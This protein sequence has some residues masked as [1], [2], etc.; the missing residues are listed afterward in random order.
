MTHLGIT[1]DVCGV[2]GI[3]GVRYKCL[4]CSDFDICEKCEAKDSHDH[5]LI[6]IKDNKRES[7]YLENLVKI[8]NFIQNH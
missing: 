2:Y 6:K 3:V 8:N 1:C 7:R 5:F 4:E